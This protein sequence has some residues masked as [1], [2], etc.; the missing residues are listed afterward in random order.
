VSKKLLALFAV[1]AAPAALA[2]A[3]AQ[4]R[5]VT[6]MTRNVYLGADLIPLATAPA[7]QFQHA[8]SG[9]FAGVVGGDPDARM[10]VIAREIAKAKPDL[11]GLQ[12][13][14][15]WRTGA[16]SPASTVRYDFSKAIVA[17][18]KQLHAGYRLAVLERAFNVEGPTDQGF[19]VRLTLGDEILVR[20]GVQVSHVRSGVFAHQLTIPTNGIGPVQVTRGWNALDARIGKTRLHFVNTHLEAYDPT[21]REAQASELVAGPLKSRRTTILVGDLNS[22]PD[23]TDPNDRLAYAA[24]AGAGYKEER[25]AKFSCCF[26]DDLKSGGWDHNVDHIM[27]KPKVRLVR[28]SVTGAET[29]PAGL[30]PS[31]H[32]G[33]VSRLRLR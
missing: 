23:L 29:T 7:D 19:D 17:R 27:A 14:S 31:D 24:L 13:I 10:K 20:K 12:E 21:V 22:G 26:N 18:L 8:A 30:H 11:V 2:P 33:V 28:S 32:G 25:T 4:A 6:V 1:L 16:T 5:D 3:A 15:L 9:V